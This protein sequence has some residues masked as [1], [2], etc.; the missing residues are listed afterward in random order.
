[1]NMATE[2]A[3]VA[4]G[5]D[6]DELILPIRAGEGT[7][8]KLE[9]VVQKAVAVVTRVVVPTGRA[10]LPYFDDGALDRS[11]ASVANGSGNDDLLAMCGLVIR[12]LPDKVRVVMQLLLD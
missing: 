3:R 1:M 2:T 7:P 4:P 11:A 12:Q 6:C 9:V 5:D 10:G 8:P